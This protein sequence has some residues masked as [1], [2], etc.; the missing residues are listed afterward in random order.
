MRRLTPDAAV[1]AR[2]T[3]RRERLLA[4]VRKVPTAEH[5]RA[6]RHHPRGLGGGT[7]GNSIRPPQMAYLNILREVLPRD[8]IVTTSCRRSASPPAVRSPV[9][10]PRTFITSGYQGTL[11][12]R[13]SQPALQAPNAQPRPA[14]GAPCTAMAVF[15]FG[16]R[17]FGDRQVQ[18]NI[19]VVTRCSTTT[20]MHNV[21]ATRRERLERRPR[22]GVRPG[23]SRF[24]ETRGIF[25]W[26]VR[27]SPGP[28]FRAALEKRWRVA[29]PVG[30]T[31]G[32]CPGIRK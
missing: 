15:M 12:S 18:F 10:K 31:C 11:G 21:G 25:G 30:S 16:C 6:S 22:G 5:Q 8:A 13:L 29:A 23:Q 20:P 9:Y 14:G 27:A 7:E 3:G 28:H 4:A 17:N 26:V 19:G 2:R 1:V 32:K 24:R